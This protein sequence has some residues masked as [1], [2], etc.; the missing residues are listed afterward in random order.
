[1]TGGVIDGFGLDAP[2][3]ELSHKRPLE[4]LEGVIACNRDLLVS[5]HQFV[6]ILEPDGV[7]RFLEVSP[8]K[9]I[10]GLVVPQE[11]PRQKSLLAVGEHPELVWSLDIILDELQLAIAHPESSNAVREIPE[12]DKGRPAGDF[13]VTI[14]DAPGWPLATVPK[15]FVEILPARQPD[16]RLGDAKPSKD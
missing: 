12:W 9:V 5:R 16:D 15:Q 11:K 1:L 7:C 14:V 13:G 3:V 2:P 6:Q 8:L 10:I 4:H